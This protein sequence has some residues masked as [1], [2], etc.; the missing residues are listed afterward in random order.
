MT[1]VSHKP[2]AVNAVVSYA[3]LEWLAGARKACA[4]AV[5]MVDLHE[6]SCLP[7][8]LFGL[9]AREAAIGSVISG[10]LPGAGVEGRNR[11]LP[12]KDVK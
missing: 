3:T 12:G 4:A 6:R 2:R 1:L 7:A 11:D 5:G 10:A 9:S 8:S